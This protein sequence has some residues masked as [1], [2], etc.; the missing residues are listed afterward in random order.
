MAK[1]EI[2]AV[3]YKGGAPSLNDLIG[4]HVPLTFNNI[5]ESIAQIRAGSRALARA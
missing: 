5:P 3:P 2:G 1:V 4:G